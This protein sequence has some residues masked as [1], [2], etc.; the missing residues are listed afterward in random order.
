MLEAVLAIGP[1]FLAAFF[2]VNTVLILGNEMLAQGL[3]NRTA[4]QASAQ[5]CLSTDAEAALLNYHL[6][7]ASGVRVDAETP[8]SSSYTFDRSQVVSGG[9]SSA[10]CDPTG[11]PTSSRDT[12]PETR[13]IWLHLTYSQRMFI[14]PWSFTISRTSLAVSNSFNQ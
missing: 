14:L 4:L 5:G 1:W 10:L 11:A 2:L 13:Y 6:F 9:G 8:P 7:L 12:V 3:L